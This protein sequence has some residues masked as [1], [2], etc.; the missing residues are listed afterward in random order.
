MNSYT[1]KRDPALYVS[2]A[3]T[4][5]RLAVGF[6]VAL[7][8]D[9]QSLLNAAV[10]AA[11]GLLVAWQVQDGQVAAILGVIQALIAL[12]VGFG[13]NLTPENQALVMSLVGTSIACFVR[14]Q[15]VAPAPPR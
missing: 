15:V 5:I 12:A 10:A 9:Q 7:T 11:A 13:L 4:T 3:A 8:V 2:L 6:G 1:L 14:T